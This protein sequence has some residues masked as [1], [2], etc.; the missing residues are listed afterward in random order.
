MELKRVSLADS[1]WNE[2]CR[3]W[4]SECA[5]FNEDFSEF[6]PASFPVLDKLAR[7]AQLVNAGVFAVPNG[8]NYSAACQANATRLPGYDG[9]V[10][11]VRH[12]VFSPSY[13][14]GG[15]L[16]LNDYEKALLSV[17]GG[18]I[19]LSYGE[20][21][22]QHIKFHLR[23]PAETQFGNSFTE[24]LKGHKAFEEVS[25]RGAWI[26]LSKSSNA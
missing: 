12:I 4:E 25:M 3:Q 20:M 14:F 24:L 13:D 17:F 5:E 6:A 7:G 18:T 22:A 21:V 8:E 16:T 15:D 1:S 2:L 23:S 11:R 26:Y 10:L 9:K 19:N